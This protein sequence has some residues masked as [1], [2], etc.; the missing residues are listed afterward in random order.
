MYSGH[1]L[2]QQ[3]LRS[4]KKKFDIDLT[5]V[6]YQTIRGNCQSFEKTVRK[7]SNCTQCLSLS[8]FH[9]P[10]PL[11]PDPIGE[12]NCPGD[13]EPL[14]NRNCTQCSQW[15]KFSVAQV[16]RWPKFPVAQVPGG[17]SSQWPKFPRETYLYTFILVDS[18]LKVF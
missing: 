4:L 3:K 9:K 18:I 7:N 15:P 16:P 8:P 10:L 17:P 6:P 1:L 5:V 12:K 14:I 2:H 13:D 11:G